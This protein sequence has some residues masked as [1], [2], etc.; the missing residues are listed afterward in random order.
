MTI[1]GNSLDYSARRVVH[2]LIWKARCKSCWYNIKIFSENMGHPEP[3]KI[4]IIKKC[5]KL[6][7][8]YG[9]VLSWPTASRWHWGPSSRIPGMGRLMSQFYNVHTTINQ[10]SIMLRCFWSR[11]F[12]IV[13]FPMDIATVSGLYSAQWYQTELVT[14][15][16]VNIATVLVMHILRT[17]QLLNCAQSFG[18]QIQGMLKYRT[19]QRYDRLSVNIRTQKLNGASKA[20]AYRAHYFMSKFDTVNSIWNLEIHLSSHFLSYSG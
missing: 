17:P 2:V 15:Y 11:G 19:T 1:S 13:E 12:C 5:P 3:T 14:V 18:H 7:R 16:H 6:L 10:L 4:V 9:R 20:A 8:I